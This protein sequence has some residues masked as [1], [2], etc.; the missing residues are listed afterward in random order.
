[1]D[2]DDYSEQAAVAAA[3]A[4]EKARRD[5]AEEVVNKRLVLLGEYIGSCSSDADM[6]IASLPVPSSEQRSEVSAYGCAC[7]P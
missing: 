6:T 2:S 1:M 4:K 3:E 5:K 7:R